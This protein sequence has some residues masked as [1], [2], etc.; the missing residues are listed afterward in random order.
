MN[1]ETQETQE[2]SYTPEQVNTQAAPSSTQTLTQTL[3]PRVN[4]YTQPEG[5]LLVTALPDVS[6]DSVHLTAEGAQIKLIAT[7]DD[8]DIYQRDLHFP[9]TTQWGE[10][11]AH[12]DGALL[13]VNL[14]RAQPERRVIS[15][16]A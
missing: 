6:P 13:H 7:R 10:L 3:T 12:W 9:K 2:T 8:G 14:R 11:S 1:T 16:H 15:V 5:W 4:L